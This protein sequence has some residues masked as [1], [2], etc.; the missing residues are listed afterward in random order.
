MMGEWVHDNGP[1]ATALLQSVTKIPHWLAPGTLVVNLRLNRKFFRGDQRRKLR[2]LLL[3]YFQLGGMQ[4][5]MTVVDQATL[6]AALAEP[7]KYGDLI[8][9]V[10]GYSEYWS[11]LDDD[12]RRS[13]LERV[14][15]G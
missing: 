10:G 12:L 1:S 2:D 6:Q 15:H 5:Q 3:T 7:E 14:E 13:I 11:R 9:R 8:I 4:L